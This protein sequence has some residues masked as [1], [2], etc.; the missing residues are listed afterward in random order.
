M[1]A[2][3]R[4]NAQ[5]III[6]APLTVQAR[7]NHANAQTQQMALCFVIVLTEQAIRLLEIL[8]GIQR[9]ASVLIH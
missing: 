5:V 1:H 4:N 2:H 8:Q 7:M 9:I 6:I 3:L